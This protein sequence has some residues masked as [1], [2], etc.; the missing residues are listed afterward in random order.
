MED[1]CLGTATLLE[2]IAATARDAAMAAG[3]SKKHFNERIDY[4]SQRFSLPRLGSDFRDMRN[5]L[6]HEG[7]LS[8]TKFQNKTVAECALAVTEALAWIDN[9]IHAA[10]GLGPVEIRR[11]PSS[12]YRGLNAFSL[13]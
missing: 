10:L 12:S 11:F 9:Y 5:D 6:V 2:I 7:T 8:G 3:I 1:L 4:A 13:D